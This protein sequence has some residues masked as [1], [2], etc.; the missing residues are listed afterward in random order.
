MRVLQGALDIAALLI[1]VVA[2]ARYEWE[3]V[4]TCLMRAWLWILIPYLLPSIVVSGMGLERSAYTMKS[5]AYSLDTLIHRDV[6]RYDV[7]ITTTTNR[8]TIRLRNQA[9]AD[10]EAFVTGAR[11]VS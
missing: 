6:Y 5:C 1:K 10:A 7:R 11:R 9:D 4:V 2:A 3:N 8:I